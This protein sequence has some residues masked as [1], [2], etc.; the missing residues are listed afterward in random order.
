MNNFVKFI[1]FI[2]IVAIGVFISTSTT[3]KSA[4]ETLS[5]PTYIKTTI[6]NLRTEVIR[7]RER[8]QLGLEHGIDTDLI[9]YKID[10]ID[11]FLYRGY[12]LSMPCDDYCNYLKEN[13]D[14]SNTNLYAENEF[15]NTEKT[16]QCFAMYLIS[17]SLLQETYNDALDSYNKGNISKDEFNNIKDN[18]LQRDKLIIDEVEKVL[19]LKTIPLENACKNK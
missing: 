19:E 2:L 18:L 5:S 7:A 11:S 9:S 14:K 6:D 8:Q 17:T 13:E 1:L 12:S 4:E 3:P 10:K 15:G 16:K